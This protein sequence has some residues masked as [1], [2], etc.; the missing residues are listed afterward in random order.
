VPLNDAFTPKELD[1]AILK[2]KS[3]ATGLKLIQK[4]MLRNL[5]NSSKTFLLHLFNTLLTNT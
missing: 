5:F 3:K 2:S 4:K 1:T